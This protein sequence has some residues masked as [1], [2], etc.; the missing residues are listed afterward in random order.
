MTVEGASRADSRAERASSQARAA[1]RDAADTDDTDHTDGVDGVDGVADLRPLAQRNRTRPTP[2]LI[3]LLTVGG[4]LGL[5]A[6]VALT[7]D[8]I[9][10]L[11]NPDY[12]PS[13]SINPVLSCG[14][15]MKTDQASVFGFPNSLIGVVGFSV[16]LTLGVL[17]AGWVT[18]PRWVWAGLAVGT[19]LGA[20]F[21]HWLVFQSLYR[22][23]ALCPYCMV[24][25]VVTI[26]LTVWT[27]LHTGRLY[28]SPGSAAGRVVD[29]VWA[30][31]G[32][33]VAA[34]FVA[35]LVLVLDRFWT[36]W[37]TLL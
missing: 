32:A 8:K 17:V 21:V 27:V 14:S 1:E 18:V 23:G 13:C 11:Q 9:K 28:T 35:V 30:W 26:P 22:I 5:V 7:I 34:W 2:G 25:W 3:G 6:A 19:V 29:G 31:R 15:V 10:L 33:V 36:Y 16:V 37:S 12:V 24:V 4:A 20:G